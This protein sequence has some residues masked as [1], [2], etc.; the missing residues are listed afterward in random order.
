M[1]I[2]AEL[3][4]LWQNHPA[5]LYALTILLGSSA[6]IFPIDSLP[7]ILAILLIIPPLYQLTYSP[8]QIRILLALTLG[9]I[10]FFLTSL[11]YQFPEQKL[12]KNGI[13]DIEMVSI[14]LNKT[15]FGTVWNYKGILKSYT[16]DGLMK[17]KNIPV[18]ISIPFE[19][20]LAR[21]SANLRYQLSGNLKTT[22][23]GKYILTPNKNQSWRV[24]NQLNTLAEQRF[25][26]KAT[27]QKYIKDSIKDQHIGAFLSGIATGEFDDRILSF[28]LNRFGLQHLMAISGLHFSIISTLFAFSFSSFFSSRMAAT[29]TLILMSLYFLFLGASPSVTRAWIAVLM[30]S[31]CLLIE[32]NNSGFNALGVAAIILLLW[33][34][35]LIGDLGFQYSFGITA[36]ILLWFS[37]LDQWLQII[38]SKRNLSEMAKA[39]SWDIHGYCLLHF[40]RQSLALNMAVNIVA[41]PLTLYH[42]HQFPLMSLVYNLFFPFL[43]SFS[44]ILLVSACLLTLIFPW[45]SVQ[46]HAL[47]E[48]YTGFVLNFAFHLPKTFDV[49]WHI[50]ELS[51]DILLIYLLV[52]LSGGIILKKIKPKILFN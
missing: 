22:T 48:I 41:V 49:T 13:A 25:S 26:V 34:P 12:L 38:F 17:A 50:P 14:K 33:D 47:N 19:D 30:G 3:A 20:S 29:M 45:L 39:D 51:K 27:V 10:C 32:K 8:A 21:P 24:L 15:P 18:F 9:M 1:N 23:Q 37:P 42:F 2:R 31:L 36:G 5:A 6:A 28:E 40:F 44:L 43:V 46:L 16:H 11:R 7:F 35:L 4:N 52:L